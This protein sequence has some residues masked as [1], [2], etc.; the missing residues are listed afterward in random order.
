MR[1]F[2]PHYGRSNNKSKKTNRDNII[3]KGQ[4]G[5]RKVV[6]L[7]LDTYYEKGFTCVGIYIS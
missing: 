1:C 6:R 3:H 2:M 5:K 7:Y 4:L